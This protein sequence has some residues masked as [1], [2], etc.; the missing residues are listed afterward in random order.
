M[1]AILQDEFVLMLGK[2]PSLECLQLGIST[3][4]IHWGDERAVMGDDEAAERAAF[5]FATIKNLHLLV[6]RT[7]GTSWWW[8]GSLKGDGSM[9]GCRRLEGPAA[10]RASLLNFRLL[11][12]AYEGQTMTHMVVYT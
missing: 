4:D 6:L 10:G 11:A 2:L 9:G 1:F 7:R 12:R 5:C 8:A 3:E